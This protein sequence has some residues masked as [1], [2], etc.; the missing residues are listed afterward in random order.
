MKHIELNNQT[1]KKIQISELIKDIQIIP[2]Y[3]RILTSSHIDTIFNNIKNKLDNKIDPIITGV[4]QI[5]NHNNDK[6]IIDGNHRL[7]AF[8]KIYEELKHDLTVIVNYIQVKN[9]EEAKMLFDQVNMVNPVIFTKVPMSKINIIFNYFKNK[10]KKIF[11]TSDKPRRPHINE[12]QFQKDIKELL[13]KD[14]KISEE[15]I[16][17]K[18]ETL[19]LELKN[20]K[21]YEYKNCSKYIELAKDKGNFFIGIYIYYNTNWLLDL[22]NIS[23]K[24]EKKKKTQ[25]PS[26]IRFEVWEKYMGNTLKGKCVCCKKTDIQIKNFEC[27]HFISEY[28]NGEISI[29][30]LRPICSICNKGMGKKNMDVWMKEMKY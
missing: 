12:I 23:H 3:Q 4:I 9:Q 29:E 15:E 17:K 21:I 1:Y 18:I 22:F 13:E 30:N 7:H 10:Y 27:G 11:K 28:N 25:I 14:N 2:E 16:I 5:C 8:K 6:Y 26:Q 24:Q 20:G 19:N